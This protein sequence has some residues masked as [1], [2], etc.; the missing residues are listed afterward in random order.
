MIT[1]VFPIFKKYQSRKGNL[2]EDELFHDYDVQKALS[3]NILKP[4]MESLEIRITP[5][6]KAEDMGIQIRNIDQLINPDHL[7]ELRNVIF[8]YIILLRI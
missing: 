1:L 7:K 5:P 6:A 8:M 3:Y 4:N 2:I